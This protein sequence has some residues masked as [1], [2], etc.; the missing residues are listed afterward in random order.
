MNQSDRARLE[1][2]CETVRGCQLIA[3]ASRIGTDLLISVSGGH[4]PHIG[5]VVLAEPCH[6]LH[7]SG[8]AAVTVSILNRPGHKDEV[9][10]R[11]MA[12]IVCART[13]QATVVAAGIH[14]DHADEAEVNALIAASRSM[15]DQLLQAMEDVEWIRQ[16]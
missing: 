7:D 16:T 5:S 2:C 15:V 10:A 11:D 4:T 8:R 3:A 13:R 12:E 6:S 14:V 9:V 1:V